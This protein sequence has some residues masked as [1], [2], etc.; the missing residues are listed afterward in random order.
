MPP[1]GWTLYSL[2]LKSRLLEE[3]IAQLWHDGLIPGEMHLGTGEEAIN[4][5]VVSHLQE[6]DAMALDHRGTAAL[7]MRGVEP[8]PICVN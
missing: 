1:D 8:V 4:A 2:M 6:G 7:L 3:A 5:G